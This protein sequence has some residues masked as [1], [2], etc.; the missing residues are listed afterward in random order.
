MPIGLQA[1]EEHALP[2]QTRAGFLFN[3]IRTP[4]LS[5]IRFTLPNPTR[6]QNTIGTERLRH[7]PQNFGV[8]HAFFLLFHPRNSKLKKI[9]SL[10]RPLQLHGPANSSIELL[11]LPST[12]QQS[13]P[14]GWMSV[15]FS[16]QPPIPQNRTPPKK[17]FL[18][19][20]NPK[21]L[22]KI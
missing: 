12:L 10:H 22:K 21:F 1:L 15:L 7:Y 5:Q 14:I 8:G 17:Y 6:I 16:R 4:R 11:P 19:H 18:F 20:E 3:L 13:A 2:D 9:R